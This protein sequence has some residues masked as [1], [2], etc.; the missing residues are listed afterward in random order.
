[1]NRPEDM[2]KAQLIKERTQLRRLLLEATGHQYE[3]F[4]G[5]RDLSVSGA[6]MV[7]W[8]SEWRERAKAAT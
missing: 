7:D 8:F 5:E 2:S 6:D 3:A 1:M 4:D